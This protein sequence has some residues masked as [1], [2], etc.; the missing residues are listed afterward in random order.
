MQPEFA[1]ATTTAMS[2]GERSMAEGCAPSARQGGWEGKHTPPTTML[3]MNLSLSMIPTVARVAKPEEKVSARG[4][5]GL[6]FVLASSIVSEG[7]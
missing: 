2:T 5:P 7:P 1:N 6:S 3:S 4:A